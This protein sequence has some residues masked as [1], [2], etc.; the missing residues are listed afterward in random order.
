MCILCTV[1]VMDCMYVYIYI[2]MLMFDDCTFL[3]DCLVLK[4][5]DGRRVFTKKQTVNKPKN[6]LKKNKI[7]DSFKDKRKCVKLFLAC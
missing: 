4:V 5:T 2:S 3:L 7:P 6:D 1:S